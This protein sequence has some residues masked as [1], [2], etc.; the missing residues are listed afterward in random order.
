M[1]DDGAMIDDR[2]GMAGWNHSS[3]IIHHGQWDDR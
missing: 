2:S 3:F 1:M